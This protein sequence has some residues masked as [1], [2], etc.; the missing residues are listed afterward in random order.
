MEPFSSFGLQAEYFFF[1]DAATTEIYT[2]GRS[3]NGHPLASPHGPSRNP[4]TRQLYLLTKK[5]NFLSVLTAE[6]R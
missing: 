1:N 6:S 5:L 4:P 3:T 2:E